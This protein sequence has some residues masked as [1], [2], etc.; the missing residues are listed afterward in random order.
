[1]SEKMMAAS[2]GNRLSGCEGI[3]SRETQQGQRQVSA[4]LF[5]SVS[6]CTDDDQQSESECEWVIFRTEWKHRRGEDG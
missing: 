4:H 2:K 3:K 1:M 6:C 5:T